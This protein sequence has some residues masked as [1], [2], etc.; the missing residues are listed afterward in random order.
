LTW[1]DRDVE[2]PLPSPA[3]RGRILE[4]ATGRKSRRASAHTLDAPDQDQVHGHAGPL[5][6]APPR[7]CK[8]EPSIR[9]DRVAPTRPKGKARRHGVTADGLTWLQERHTSPVGG[10][11]VPRPQ[12]L[13]GCMK[14][15]EN[16]TNRT[17]NTGNVTVTRCPPGKARAPDAKEYGQATSPKGRRSAPPKLAKAPL[18]AS[19]QMAR[20]AFRFSARWRSSRDCRAASRWIWWPGKRMSRSPEAARRRPPRLFHFNERSALRDQA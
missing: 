18:R 8:G 7:R 12:S 15:R 3:N 9:V 11:S 16:R 4:N 14:T 13:H 5:S 10:R 6:S 1:F 20:S 2:T 17:M 19:T